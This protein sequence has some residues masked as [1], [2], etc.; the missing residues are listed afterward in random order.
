MTPRTVIIPFPQNEVKE[1]S[2]EAPQP[3]QPDPSAAK[4]KL[5]AEANARGWIAPLDLVKFEEK[6]G[7][8]GDA[9]HVRVPDYIGHSID[10]ILQVG[11]RFLL[12]PK[13]R[14]DFVR[15]AVVWYVRRILQEEPFRE[16]ADLKLVQLQVIHWE[17]QRAARA[18]AE[19]AA[20][21]DLNL[22]SLR[23]FVSLKIVDLELDQ[24]AEHLDRFFDLVEQT[25]Q[26]DQA[27][28][29]QMA[30]KIREDDGL[31][32]AVGQLHMNGYEVVV[33][34]VEAEASEDEGE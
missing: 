31:M 21:F 13:T 28:G 8:Y 20:Q 1:G 32:R 24:A 14:S 4:K 10:E 22:E 11:R 5:F 34:G 29:L 9:M 23:K 27:K 17:M 19:L 15:N 30:R 7:R 18:D 33:P 25:K 3:S 16:D 12:F 26:I 6:K 2:V